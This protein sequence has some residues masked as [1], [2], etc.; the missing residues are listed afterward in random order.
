MEDIH[1][2]ALD[3]TAPARTQAA[4]VAP[5]QTHDRLMS[6]DALRGFDMF[7]IIGGGPIIAGLVNGIGNEALKMAILPQLKHVPWEGFAFW[8]LIMPLFLF[9]AG[10][11]MPFSFG[12]RL[13]QGGPARLYRHVIVRVLVLFALGLVAQG[14]LLDYDLSTLHIFCNTLQAIATGYLIAAIIVLN[15]RLL[16]QVVIT[17]A[18]LAV[19][20]AL[21]M[22]VP[23]PEHGA[24]VLTPEGNL[25]IYLDKLILG[26]FQDQTSYTW[27]LS[28]LTFA[29]TI[30][31]GVFAG[32]TLRWRRHKLIRVLLLLVMGGVCL[33]LGL[34]WDGFFPIIKH[35][36]T[37]SCVLFAGGLSF[38]LLALFYLVIDVMGLRFLAF[39][40]VVIGMNAIF[41][42]MAV[43]LINFRHIG[44]RF[45]ENLAPWLGPWNDLVQ[46]GA[47]F[48]V[49]WLILYYMYRNKTFIKV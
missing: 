17:G 16:L 3:D 12:K 33:G 24:G 48:A 36:W 14:N 44:G 25:A 5:V 39:G 42:Y 9:L 41:A 31:L 23:V 26:R 8:D 22:F 49:L 29:C 7:L 45:V 37:S 32:Q 18:L 20:W 15:T 40:W 4:T 47:A 35:L 19:F 28:S 1:S 13:D 10:V 30:L 21:M 27:I 46:A 43:H 6:I 38:L 2:P 34:A 11:S